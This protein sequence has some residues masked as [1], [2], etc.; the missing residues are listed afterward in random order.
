MKNNKDE[1]LK[2]DEMPAKEA[3]LIVYNMIKAYKKHVTP[4]EIQQGTGL[5]SQK[6]EE[7]LSFLIKKYYCNASFDDNGQLYYLFNLFKK[8]DSVSVF[9]IISLI[10]STI[11]KLILF[12]FKFIFTIIFFAL[13]L[14]VGTVIA[15]ILTAVAKSPQPLIALFAGLFGSLKMLFNNLKGVFT[16]KSYENTSVKRNLI[17]IVIS[18]AFGEEKKPKDK[19]T[20]EKRIVEFLVANKGKIT[21]T[22][23]A[24]ITSWP[25]EKCN[26]E[27]TYMMVNYNG[28]VYVTDN[29]IIVY[30]FKDME[31]KEQ[32]DTNNPDYYIWNHKDKVGSWND[33][34]SGAN[35]AITVIS[36]VILS[37]CAVLFLFMFWMG[38]TVNDVLSNLFKIPQ[39]DEYAFIAGFI[40]DLIFITFPL[41]SV[42]FIG[43]YLICSYISRIKNALRNSRL[44]KENQ[45]LKYLR[46]IYSSLPYI[47]KMEL[48]RIKEQHLKKLLRDYNG[49]IKIYENGKISYSFEF[50]YNELAEIKKER[51]L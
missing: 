3:A 40:G 10:I 14:T 34:S 46:D 35:T 8:R 28:D 48:E 32:A 44:K 39:M 30:Q 47:T 6:T 51:Y 1:T 12:I 42:F 17:T 37:I 25:L 26:Q 9:E 18:Y 11:I 23:V 16:G 21:I 38:V 43:F 19:L 33:N 27:L 31:T 2:H 13:S 45:Y 49:D 4:K 20:L 24:L 5:S 22:E 41:H 36:Y 15:V 50:F 29:G 7:A